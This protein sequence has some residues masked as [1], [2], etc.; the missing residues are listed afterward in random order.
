MKLIRNQ[1]AAMMNGLQRDADGSGVNGVKSQSPQNGGAD[2]F[3][4]AI[5]DA[6]KKE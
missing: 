2:E 5:R 6:G 4:D 1:G 3:L